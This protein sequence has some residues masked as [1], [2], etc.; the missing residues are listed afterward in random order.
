[1]KK[2]LYKK[3]SI[4]LC[5]KYIDKKKLEK[6]LNN[7]YNNCNF[8]Y[9]KEKESYK[10]IINNKV[11]IILS[12]GY[13]IIFKEDFFKRNPKCKIINIHMGYLPHGR[14]IYPNLL[15]IINKKKCGFSI[16][17]INSKKI[18]NGPLLYR[19][20]I[21]FTNK[22]TMKTLFYRIKENLDQYIDKNLKKILTK[23]TTRKFSRK[24]KYY[25]RKEANFYFE[26][27]PDSWNTKIKDIKKIKFK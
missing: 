20:H 18:D 23:K 22:E 25:S 6:N 15:S 19:K 5:G 14:G 12:Y 8:Y 21:M 24:Y 1:M 13:G 2:Y 27:L 17:L 16:H 4:G 10:K 7:I 3:I 9:L 11:N 26:K